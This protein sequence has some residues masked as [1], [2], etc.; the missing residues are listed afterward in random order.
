MISVQKASELA[1]DIYMPI[2]PNTFDIIIEQLSVTA[3]IAMIDGVTT[4]TFAGSETPR[5][6]IDDFRIIP[7][8]HPQLGWI[9]RGFWA[10]ME[11]SFT[12]IRPFLRGRIS[13]QGHSLGCAHATILAG[14]CAFAGIPVEQLCLFAPPH[15]GFATLRSVV[16]THVKSI[17][18]FRNGRDPVPHMPWPYVPIV[19][20][21]ALN[22]PGNGDAFS[23]HSINLYVKALALGAEIQTIGG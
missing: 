16:V 5:D 7:H 8:R 17:F 20:A 23:D 19:Q 2:K 3:G 18:S 9:H 12:L 4:V 10:D 14:L 21:T 6:W 11:D 22:C 13:I 1:R 15:V